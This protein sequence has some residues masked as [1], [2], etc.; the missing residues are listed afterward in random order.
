MTDGG[1]DRRGTPPQPGEHT[2]TDR[3]AQLRELFRCPRCGVTLELL[4]MVHWHR[5]LELVASCMPCNVIE[6]GEEWRVRRTSAIC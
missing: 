1:E 4:E 3:E 2:A 6:T 5:G